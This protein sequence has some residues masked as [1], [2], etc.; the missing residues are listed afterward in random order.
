MKKINFSDWPSHT[1]D[2]A[3]AVSDVI[4]SNNTNYWSGFQVKEFES[5]FAKFSDSKYA[6]AMANGSV[7]L[8]AALRA[9]G[10]QNGDEVIVASRTYLASA[11]SIVNVGGIPIFSDIDRDTQ[12]IKAQNISEKITKK[13]KA[14]ICVHLAG[15]PCDMD[16]IIKLANS[17]NILVIEDCAQ[18]HGARYKG[19][20]VGSFGVI[21]CWSFC[22]DKIISTGGEGGMVTTNDYNLWS[23]MWSFK[24][25]GKDWDTVNSNKKDVGFKWVHFSFGTNLRMTEMQAAIGRIQLKKMSSWNRLRRK[26]AKKIWDFAKNLK[27]IRVPSL[28]CDLCSE[29]EETKNIC[30][31]NVHAAYKCYVF[32]DGTKIERDRIIEIINKKGVPCFSGSCSEVYLEEAFGK[33]KLRPSS[34]LPV[35]K[36]LGDTSLM[37]LCHPTIT[38]EEINMTCLA[39]QEAVV[40]CFG[41]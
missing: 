15:W 18:A 30:E 14:I 38:E 34:R 23:K 32:I 9:I 4:L 31:H 36:E 17:H 21:G 19:K 39:L 24:D 11:S 1:E 41:N 16:P 6:I 2:E 20:S 25:H 13:T 27:R 22:Q 3:K 5:E 40:E 37:F 28:L 33:A 12:V 26:N 10:I 8:E 29:Q 7:A 35:A